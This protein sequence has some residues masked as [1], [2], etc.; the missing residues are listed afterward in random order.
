MAQLL[1]QGIEDAL[2]SLI[3]WSVWCRK[4]ELRLADVLARMSLR[5]AAPKKE[6]PA[7]YLELVQNSF[8][9][10]D[11]RVE[12]YPRHYLRQLLDCPD[13]EL[14]QRLGI[15]WKKHPNSRLAPTPSARQ[16]WPHLPRMLRD[17][18]VPMTD[19]KGA[20]VAASY[21][22]IKHGPQLVVEPWLCA[23]QKRGLEGP[24]LSAHGA[25]DLA[26][27]ILLDGAR[28][29]ETEE[30]RDA[31]I[32]VAPFLLDDSRVIEEW[33]F[34]HLLGNAALLFQFGT[35]VFNARFP[36]AVARSPASVSPV[37]GALVRES[38]AY[39]ARFGARPELWLSKPT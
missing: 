22:K 12:I 16:I 14:P 21:N 15:P 36:D 31:S 11:R 19:E 23:A 2:S 10:D 26:L 35:T 32:R 6:V 38:S 37:V 24:E 18:I 27:R 20:L 8:S 29:Q 13:E 5:F 9:K 7:G 4:P 39:L 30:E 3:A 33:Y 28:T 34:R 1:G 25:T 17:T